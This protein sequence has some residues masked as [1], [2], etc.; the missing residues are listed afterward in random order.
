MDAHSF[1]ILSSAFIPLLYS[2][3]IDKIYGPLP[4]LTVFHCFG[5][6]GKFALA[7]QT[8]RQ[9]P[10]YFLQRSPLP[11]PQ[12]PAP[13]IM[14]LRKYLIN[15]HFGEAIPE[16]STRSLA[17]PIIRR[18]EVA[19]WL[20]CSPS[21]GISLTAELP[22]NFPACLT[23][24]DQETLRELHAPQQLDVQATWLA[25]P[26]LTPLLRKTIS[27]L[28]FPE[29]MA[30]MIDLEAGGGE[31][32]FY[33]PASN[34][35]SPDIIPTNP[36]NPSHYF[37]WPLPDSLCEEQGLELIEAS[38][39]TS[40]S[41]FPLTGDNAVP[42]A[43][44]L[45]SFIDEQELHAS[46]NKHITK[47]DKQ[48]SKRTLKRARRKERALEQEA[49]RLEKL[50][51][52]QQ[53]AKLIQENL[54]RLDPNA[55]YDHITLNA[56]LPSGETETRTISLDPRLTIRDNMLEIFKKAEKGKRGLGIVATRQQEHR[57]ALP[58]SASTTQENTIS[59]LPEKKNALSTLQNWAS[60]IEQDKKYPQKNVAYFTSSDGY[61]L[62]R[63]KNAQGNRQILKLSKGH[64]I[65]L[66]AQEG[67]SAHVIIK[68]HHAQ[69]QVPER[70][71]IEASQLVAEKSWLKESD[72]AE[73]MMA[74]VKN[75]QSI[76]GASAGTVKVEKTLPSV[77]IKRS[78]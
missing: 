59:I 13:A 61:T 27:A 19:H 54:W 74:L 8:Q 55:K 76:K 38:N 42:L 3:R 16:F 17:L 30:L 15:A 70:T 78:K 28:D 18:G 67:P 23:W 60:L 36:A 48:D 29:A 6:V 56:T 73:I 34:A 24:P 11:N 31:L 64:D 51:D 12:T 63:G 66:H 72:T 14:R 52:R 75:V 2:A 4:D 1:R 44:Q 71:I 10:R 68:R 69:D 9:Q 22:E 25:Y 32:F 20:I 65:W 7:L 46:F 77:Y 37:A 53:D 43:L 47:D 62:L 35:N 40:L 39:L 57:S 21:Q 5:K 45:T 49:L 33:R 58:S 26:T 41:H 50:V